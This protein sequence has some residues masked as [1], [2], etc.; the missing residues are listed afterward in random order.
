MAVEVD[1]RSA[2]VVTGVRRTLFR[3]SLNPSIQ[4]GE[5]AVSPDGQ[6]FLILDPVGN[7][8]QSISLLLNWPAKPR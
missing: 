2:S 7:Q 1:T 4:V 3:T 6:R 5:Y 8:S